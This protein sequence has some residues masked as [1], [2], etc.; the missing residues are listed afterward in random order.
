[1]GDWPDLLELQELDLSFT[2]RLIMLPA[3][4]RFNLTDCTNIQEKLDSIAPALARILLDAFCEYKQANKQLL[5]VPKYM[6]LFKQLVTRSSALQRYTTNDIKLTQQWVT[7]NVQHDNRR[8]L[9]INTLQHLFKFHW[10]SNIVTESRNSHK[11]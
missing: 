11:K 8:N 7:H 4:S 9:P 2:N 6:H 5:P 1:M 3:R 10:Q